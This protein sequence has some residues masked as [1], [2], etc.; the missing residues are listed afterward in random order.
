MLFM[1]LARFLS[2]WLGEVYAFFISY[3]NIGFIPWDFY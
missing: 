1:F 3:F 2:H